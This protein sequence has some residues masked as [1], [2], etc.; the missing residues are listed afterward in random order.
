MPCAK[1]MPHLNTDTPVVAAAAAAP[2]AAPDVLASDEPPDPALP[3]PLVGG[4]YA[5][6]R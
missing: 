3:S 4:I 2:D 1:P 6:R 5:V